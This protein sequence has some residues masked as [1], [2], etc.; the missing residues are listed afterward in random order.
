MA[1]KGPL[2]GTSRFKSVNALA[3]DWHGDR[4]RLLEALRQAS[5]EAHRMS[6][7]P[8]RDLRIVH[9]ARILDAL[10]NELVFAPDRKKAL[11][12]P[13]EWAKK[14][15]KA[16]EERECFYATLNS[17]L[18]PLAAQAIAA[19]AAAKKAHKLRREAA[20][21]FAEV[22]EPAIWEE[23]V[24]ADGKPVAS[25]ARVPHLAKRILRVLP[26]NRSGNARDHVGKFDSVAFVGDPTACVESVFRA[27]WKVEL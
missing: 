15:Q 17:S 2:I 26:L 6:L 14:R 13:F 21:A 16:A 23:L 8:A 18:R 12:A 7:S 3:K 27:L 1:A 11:Q 19:L 20:R 22:V 9:L 24:D 5:R 4:G 25:K 10:S